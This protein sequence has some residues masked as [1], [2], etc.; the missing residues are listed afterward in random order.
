MSFSD[1]VKAKAAADAA[2]TRPQTPAAQQSSPLSAVAQQPPRAQQEQQEVPQPPKSQSPRPQQTQGLSNGHCEDSSPK[3]PAGSLS[4]A[5]GHCENNVVFDTTETGLSSPR[6]DTWFATQH[7]DVRLP[8][9][10]VIGQSHYTFSNT[11]QQTPQQPQAAPRTAP[12]SNQTMHAVQTEP[13]PN[14]SEVPRKQQ[15]LRPN[16]H[17]PYPQRDAPYTNGPNMQRSAAPGSYESYQPHQH[18]HHQHHHHQTPYQTQGGA[19]QFQG[20][21]GAYNYTMAQHGIVP[22]SAPAPPVR[23][24][25]S[26]FTQRPTGPYYPPYDPNPQPPQPPPNYHGYVPPPGS[27]PPPGRYYAPPSYPPAPP[28][29]S[30]TA[31][32]D[33]AQ[34]PPQQ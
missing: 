29:Y 12:A 11:P 9:G 21:W 8:D 4:A 20:N 23:G 32:H 10:C 19:P 22:S 7:E 25:R 1:K 3:V 2:R 14:H 13:A 28:S 24:P 16:H 6:P 17:Q 33:G 5:N 34:H 30:I 18:Q 27:Y 15:Q 31:S 26:V